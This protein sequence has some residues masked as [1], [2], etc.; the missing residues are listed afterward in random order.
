MI[1]FTAV[2]SFLVLWGSSGDLLTLVLEQ[3]ESYF[4]IFTYDFIL[5]C[6]VNHSFVEVPVWTFSL[7]SLI[8]LKLILLSEEK[9]IMIYF[10]LPYVYKY[11]LCP[12]LFAEDVIVCPLCNFGIFVKYQASK[13]I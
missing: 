8:H 9:E 5:L 12:A 11:P 3:L 7:S 4:K 6:N 10:I 2:R 13:I 1:G